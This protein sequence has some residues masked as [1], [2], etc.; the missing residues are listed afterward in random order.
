MYQYGNLGKETQFRIPWT[1]L[2]F[3][4]PNFLIDLTNSLSTNDEM[5][6]NLLRYHVLIL[7][8]NFHDVSI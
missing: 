2:T 8:A 1:T 5:I 6:N 7:E 4:N 3:L